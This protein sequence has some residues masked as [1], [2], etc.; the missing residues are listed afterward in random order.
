M[1]KRDN[2]KWIYS[3]GIFSIKF[4][5]YERF[6]ILHIALKKNHCKKIQSNFHRSKHLK[7]FNPIFTEANIFCKLSV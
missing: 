7:K 5:S 6:K 3:M 4:C 1:H 2:G